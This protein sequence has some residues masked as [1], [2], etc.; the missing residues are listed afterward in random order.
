MAQSLRN[1]DGWLN[2]TSCVLT[3]ETLCTSCLLT[4]LQKAP[5]ESWNSRKKT[6]IDK[7]MIYFSSNAGQHIL[8]KEYISPGPTPPQRNIWIWNNYQCTIQKDWNLLLKPWKCQNSGCC[9]SRKHYQIFFFVDRHTCT[10]RLHLIFDC[11]I[12]NYF[13]TIKIP[14]SQGY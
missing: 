3:K 12:T 13:C 6:V 1:I 9:K 5:L 14:L 7:R 8:G 4:G 10:Q 2:K 11:K